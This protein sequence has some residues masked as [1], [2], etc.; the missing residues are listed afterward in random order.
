MQYI[1]PP[2]KAPKNVFHKTFHSNLAGHEI[3]YNIYLPPDYENSNKRYPVV[4]H[5]H[6][7][8]G[9]E[10]SE[11]WP[12]EKVYHCRQAITVFPN[13]SLPIENLENFPLESV[14]IQELI[15]YIDSEYKTDA[16]CVGR[17]ISG[18][19][20]GGGL[21]FYYAVKYPELFSK[22]I[23]YAG[24]YHHYYDQGFITVDADPERALEFCDRILNA[25]NHS[26]KNILILLNSNADKIRN[27]LQIELHVGTSDV[28]YCDNEILHL[29]LDSLHIPHEYKK[30][31]GAAHELDKIV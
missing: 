29:H 13:I 25:E 12:M 17:E 31:D 4:Y 7:F 26:E 3:G 24:T 16:I 21:A 23:A 10:S 18:F 22:V 1:N 5:I 30:F 20:M 27:T 8:T 14:I 11:I 15:P 28:L 19:S 9:T 2:S 6:G